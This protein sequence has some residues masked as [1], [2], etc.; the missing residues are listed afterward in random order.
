MIFFQD[1]Y[2]L[3]HNF[4]GTCAEY[5]SAYIILIIESLDHLGYDFQR[6]LDQK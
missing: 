4:K 6:V 5:L 1:T 2:R 3:F